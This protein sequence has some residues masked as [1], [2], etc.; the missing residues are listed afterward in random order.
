MPKLNHTNLP[1]AEVAPLRDFFTRYFGFVPIHEPAGSPMAVLRGEDGYILNIMKRRATDGEFPKDFHVGFLFDA[2]DEV[3]AMHARLLADN[4]R[5]GDV[6]NMTR[7]G[8]TSVTFYCFAPN[9]VM[10]EVSCYSASAQHPN[11]P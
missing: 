10:V 5:A 6:E 3:H 7:R 4:V 2:P 8:I 11:Q 1:V 9:D